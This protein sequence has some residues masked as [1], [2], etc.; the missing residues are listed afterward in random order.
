MFDISYPSITNSVSYLWKLYNDTQL[1]CPIL[2]IKMIFF[3]KY[4]GI[5]YVT[6]IHV[7]LI[8]GGPYFYRLPFVILDSLVYSNNYDFHASLELYL[9]LVLLSIQELRSCHIHVLPGVLV[10]VAVGISVFFSNH[11]FWEPSHGGIVQSLSLNLDLRICTVSSSFG[12]LPSFG[13]LCIFSLS[14]NMDGRYP[15]PPLDIIIIKALSHYVG[16]AT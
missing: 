2:Y 1:M 9:I 7:G 11:L 3:C 12:L 13:W 6:K 8:F 4:V 16:L 15:E 10:V 5:L 14:L